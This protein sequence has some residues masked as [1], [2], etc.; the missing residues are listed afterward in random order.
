MSLGWREGG[1]EKGRER[2]RERD[3][4]RGNR[5]SKADCKQVGMAIERA[6]PLLGERDKYSA[7]AHLVGD[8]NR[9]QECSYSTLV[10]ACKSICLLRRY[11]DEA[12]KEKTFS[13]LVVLHLSG[14]FFAL[15][16]WGTTLVLVP[17]PSLRIM[18]HAILSS[19]PSPQSVPSRHPPSD[20]TRA[21]LKVGVSSEL[22]SA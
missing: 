21:L 7:F 15:P 1:R 13:L 8:F 20:A 22:K 2:E 18:E 11:V 14:A 12:F 19:H 17:G 9:L 10:S 3:G 16:R 5:G 4:A 6:S